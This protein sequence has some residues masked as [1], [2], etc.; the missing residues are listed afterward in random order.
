M[1]T[2]TQN[3]ANGGAAPRTDVAPGESEL[4][5]LLAEFEAK[6]KTATAQ[7]A[8]AKVVTTMKPVVQFVEREM[9]DRQRQ[10]LEGDI[11]GAVK[12]MTE[13][14]DL[15]AVP[16]R[17]VRGFLE[18]YGIENQT[19]A[20]AFAERKSDPTK[21]QNE[22]GNARTLFEAE[23]KQLPGSKVR[24]DIAA[25]KAAVAGSSSSSET[26]TDDEKAIAKMSDTEFLEFRRKRLAE[27]RGF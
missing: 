8:V 19:F 10:A 14:E 27:A 3:S 6:G 4:D 17:L 23:L 18:G 16:K 1:T 11:E 22:L 25:A 21:W 20:K 15:K 24:T 7:D 9:Q 2:E 12:F 13:P 5:R 26:P